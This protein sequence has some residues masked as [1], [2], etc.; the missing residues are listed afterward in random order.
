MVMR[1]LPPSTPAF[2]TATLCYQAGTEQWG[3][4]DVDILKVEEGDIGLMRW[5]ASDTDR[6]LVLLHASSTGPRAMSR[7]ASQLVQ[8]SVTVECPGFVGYDGTIWRTGGDSVTA[9]CVIAEA[10][11]AR[12][13]P[14]R[15]VLFGHSMGGAIA[16][17]TA[18]TAQANGRPLAG[19]VL[20]EPILLNLLDHTDPEMKAAYDWD[21]AVIA[22][23]QAETAAGNPEAGVRAFVEAWNETD[24][25]ALP[26]P[27]R[28][29]LTAM[30]PTILAE[31]DAVGPLS[32][33]RE[34]LADLRTPTLA[35]SG[36]TGPDMPRLIGDQLARLIPRTAHDRLPGIGHMGPLLRP[37]VVAAR[38]ASFVGQVL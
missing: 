33:D 3:H 14:A 35:L 10:V 26:A 5:L 16:L 12:H 18:L 30:A 20:F 25:T 28:A 23:L 24:W 22:R 27:A 21:R 7:M 36:A 13:D 29:H 38:V 4:G 9:N 15:T 17:K 11:L 1:V 2:R 31:C 8:Q 34:G 37:D 6:T 19:L 32:F